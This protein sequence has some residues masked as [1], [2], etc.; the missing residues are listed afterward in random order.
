MLAVV[1]DP[2]VIFNEHQVGGLSLV[3][4]P[5]SLV[6]SPAGTNFSTGLY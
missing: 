3:Q 2:F 4:C 5:G 1:V 6:L